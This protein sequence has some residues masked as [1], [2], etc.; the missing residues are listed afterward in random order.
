MFP[1]K[2]TP[3]IV[4][5]VPSQTELLFDLGVGDSVV[6]VTKFCIYPPAARQK[7]IVGGTKNLDIARIIAL[8]PDLIIANKEE[9]T[10]A[11]IV[12]LQQYC[13]V[14]LSDIYTL[15]DAL[16]MIRDIGAL[17]HTTEKADLLSKQIAQQFE[18]LAQHRAASDIALRKA[19]YFIWRKPYMVAASHTFIQ[20][21]LERAGFANVFGD[22]ARYPI[23]TAA[24]LVAA[25]PD[26]ILL[27]SEP[28]PFK[29][30]HLTELQAICPTAQV[31][32]ID[33]E[34]FSWYG[35]RLLHSAAYFLSL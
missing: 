2:N 24:D 34:L 3:R 4:S 20:D 26:V 35:S 21:M 17:T 19:A 11:D 15:D 27:S 29:T 32:L 30:A 5:V 13:T 8:R 25:Q 1:Q 22:R 12:A 10:E 6:G 31:Q 14:W 18:E 9:N 28:Y 7:A 33:G 16:R 23:I